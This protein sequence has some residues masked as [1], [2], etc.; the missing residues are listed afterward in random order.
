MVEFNEH[1]D[2]CLDKQEEEHLS[3]SQ[4]IINNEASSYVNDNNDVDCVSREGLDDM[5]ESIIP[6]PVGFS[7]DV[8]NCLPRDIKMEQVQSM[9]LTNT[10]TT[11]SIGAATTVGTAT[12]SSSNGSVSVGSNTKRS[13]S[14]ARKSSSSSSR[15]GLITNCF[16]KKL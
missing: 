5:S 13:S 2:V 3:Q 16:K 14:K 9:K 11:D 7:E 12:S 1:I 6:C 10:K 4:S 15:K 8:W